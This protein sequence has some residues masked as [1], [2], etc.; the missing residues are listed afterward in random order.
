MAVEPPPGALDCVRVAH[1]DRAVAGGSEHVA[2]GAERDA[3]ERVAAVP[4]EPADELAGARIPEVD[5]SLVLADA[6]VP[7]ERRGGQ[8]DSGD[9]APPGRP[10]QA[11]PA[12][13]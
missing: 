10:G 6:R 4:R 11:D 2:V 1:P 12:T 7:R 13:A 3:V 8:G 5:H 9:G